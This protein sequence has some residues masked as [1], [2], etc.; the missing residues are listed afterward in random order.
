MSIA[1]AIVLV[2]GAQ[3]AGGDLTEVEQMIMAERAVEQHA[4]TLIPTKL[5]IAP[6]GIGV[7]A[8]S[9][10]ETFKTLTGVVAVSQIAR[11]YWPEKGTSKRPPLCSS[12]DGVYGIINP[13]PEQEQVD[14]GRT[15]RVPHEAIRLADAG[16]AVP[17]AYSCAECPLSKW[18]S[19]HQGGR[20]GRR[21][22]CKELRRLVLLVD[23][24]TQPVLLTLP[25]TSAKVWDQFCS[26]QELKRSSYFAT[27]VELGLEKAT[28]EDGAPYNTIT[29][30]AT[31]SLKGDPVLVKAVIDIRREFESLVR[32]MG[33]TP[34]EYRTGDAAGAT[35]DGEVVD[36][37]QAEAEAAGAF[38]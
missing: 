15:A 25:P 23:G 21:Q 16:R 2:T 26:D 9:G 4:F 28:A 24:W 8:S 12:G 3:L 34:D 10:G 30:K 1:N 33:I 7:F 32:S 14:A 13:Q 19:A 22:A 35:V 31:G 20:Q 5:T 37:A 38:M 36:A 27:R 6:G 29:V 17:E 11:A 18:E